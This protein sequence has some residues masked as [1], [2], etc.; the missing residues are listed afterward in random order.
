MAQRRVHAL[1]HRDKARLCYVSQTNSGDTCRGPVSATDRQVAVIGHQQHTWP[2]QEFHIGDTEQA[3]HGDFWN[4]VLGSAISG[5]I[6]AMCFGLVVL[7]V[8]YFANPEWSAEI[9]RFIVP[10]SVLA[11]IGVGFCRYIGRKDER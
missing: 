9:L 6:I 3:M 8:N 5:F 10:A 4:E 2:F 7:V 11:A 1:L